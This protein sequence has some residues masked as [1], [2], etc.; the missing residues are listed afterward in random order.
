MPTAE[1]T[2]FVVDDDAAVRDSLQVLL[3]SV[4]IRSQTYAT[5]DEFLAGHDPE[6]P[7]CLVLDI[8]MPGMNG[9]ELQKRLNADGI[10]LPIIVVSGHGDV[11]MAVDA[12]QSGAIDFLE[13]PLR[14]HTLLE[15]IR[16]GF[17]RDAQSRQRRRECASMTARLASLTD[18]ERE[19]LDLAVAGKQNKAMA[20]ELG[21]SHK[22]IEFHRKKIMD[23]MNA[24]NIAD[25]VRMVF[26]AEP[27]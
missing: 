3:K 23:K 25:L 1:P 15:R 9:L 2:V 10:A 13:K 27:R 14:Q 16:T 26:E 12:V 21:L 11:R 17:E 18:R 20:A 22:T 19:V 24:D 8:R 4:D 6:Q 7:G 5:A